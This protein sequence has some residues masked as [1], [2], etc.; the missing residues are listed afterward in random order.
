MLTKDQKDAAHW[1][2]F[3]YGQEGYYEPGGFSYLIIQAYQKA[4]PGNKS[5]LRA[6][7]PEIAEAM[8]LVDSHPNGIEKLKL[9]LK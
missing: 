8:D 3:Y 4:D 1:V 9:R 6:V 5:K 2:L 7:F